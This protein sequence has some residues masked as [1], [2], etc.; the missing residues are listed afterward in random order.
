MLSK[1]YKLMK[2][3]ELVEEIARVKRLLSTNKKPNTQKQNRIYLSRLEKEYR[4]YDAY[5][6]C[7]TNNT[8]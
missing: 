1:S 4:E 7:R 2:I 3:D 6:R 8:R 5:V